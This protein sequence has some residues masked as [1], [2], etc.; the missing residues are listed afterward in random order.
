[1][2]AAENTSSIRERVITGIALLFPAETAGISVFFIIQLA[3][4]PEERGGGVR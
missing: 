4:R 3:G 1:M 2:L